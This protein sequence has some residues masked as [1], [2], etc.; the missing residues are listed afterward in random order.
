MK[1]YGMYTEQGDV[2]VIEGFIIYFHL[3]LIIFNIC[4]NT[5]NDLN[6]T[7]VSLKVPQINKILPKIGVPYKNKNVL[8]INK[9]C[10]LKIRQQKK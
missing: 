1:T 10:T 2:L 7:A 6:G 9:N 5:R 8:L 4:T 3:F